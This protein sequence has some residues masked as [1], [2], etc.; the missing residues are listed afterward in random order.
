MQTAVRGTS[1]LFDAFDQPP[2][3]L[4]WQSFALVGSKNFLDSLEPP[5]RVAEIGRGMQTAF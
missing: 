5:L 3:T 1:A 4:A 2:A